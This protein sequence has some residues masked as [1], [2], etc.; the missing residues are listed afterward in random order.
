MLVIKRNGNIEP[1]SLDKITKRIVFLCN[2]NP[3]LNID[4]IIVAVKTVQG[5]YNKVT[6][7]ELDT[8]AAEISAAL[9]TV[10]PDFSI[11]AARIS[12]SNL[13]KQ[14]SDSFS[15]V[16]ENLF[17]FTNINTNKEASL[18]DKNL[19]NVVKT[20][21]DEIN[22]WICYDRDYMFDY[23]GFKTLERSYLLKINNKIVE[24]PQHMILRVA[25]GIHYET[26]NK[27]NWLQEAKKTYDLISQGFFTHATPTLFN[28]GT[29]YPQLS[30]CFLL[31]ITADSLDGIYKTLTDCAKISKHAGG[32]G[33]SMQKIRAQNSYIAGTNGK[34]NGII[35]ML[36][37]Y[38]NTARYVD[39][40]GGKR[41]GSIA[42]FCKDTE[43]VTINRGVQKIQDVKVG[44]LVVTHKNR[45]KPVTQVHT[46]PLNDR[47]I[48]KLIVE[49]SKDVYVTGNHRFW[50]CIQKTKKS[51]I[52][53]NSVETLKNSIFLNTCYIAIPEKRNV[54]RQINLFNFAQKETK[55]KF[56]KQK[57]YMTDDFATLI[58]IWFGEG[59]IK[60]NNAGNIQGIGFFSYNSNKSTFVEKICK[61]VF[62]VSSI[63]HN[64]VNGVATIEI[65]LPV[66]G[67]IFNDLFKQ[68]NNFI[69]PSI[70][71]SWKKTLVES[72]IAGLLTTSNH[73]EQ[74]NTLLYISYYNF[75]TQIYHLCKINGI[76]ASFNKDI[77]IKNLN[78]IYTV[79][80]PLNDKIVN[81]ARQL[82][83]DGTMEN[84]IY[85][86]LSKKLLKILNI[87]EVD[88]KDDFV[89]T[90]GVA[91]DHS[92]SV[93]G[94]LAENCYF[95]PWH[96]D[97][98]D[99]LDLKKNNGSEEQ[100]A[101][102]LFYAMWIP[103]LFM[104]RVVENKNWSL[105]C[106]NECPGL[107]ETHGKEFED[108]YLKYEKE[109]KSRRTVS[110]LSLMTKIAH[111]QIE[112]GNP[113]IL[114]KDIINKTSNQQNLG[115]IKSSNLC[116]EIC[117]YTDPN[118]IAVCNLASICLP[119]YVV[120]EKFNHFML[121]D[122][123]QHIVQN[124]NKV[125]DKT[126][127]P[128]PE[129]KYSNL[130]HRPM[131]IGVQGLAD[132]FVKLK[133]PFDSEGAK[134]LNKEIFETIYFSAL[135]TSNTLAKKFGP[136]D[137]FPNSPL[138]KG[139]FHFDLMEKDSTFVLN[140]RWDWESLRSRIINEG[141]YNSLF[142]ALMPT[143]STS[144]IMGNNDAFE[145]FTSNIY[146][147]R[148][149]AGEFVVVN[150]HLINDLI[151][152]NLWTEEI[153]ESLIQNNG[154]VQ[155]LE[156]PVEI[157]NLYKTAFEIPPKTII[158]MAKD[159]QYFVDQSQSMNIFIENP[160]VDKLIKMH[161]YS[162]KL[163]LKTGLYYLRTK[164]STNAVKFT[165]A[166]DKQKRRVECSEECLTCSA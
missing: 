90:L 43:I 31:D 88:R 92:Y 101:R 33:V 56:K 116:A 24:R 164:P 9:T 55:N 50:S 159:R 49:K 112:T 22:S 161:V 87:V 54:N 60:F 69:L 115:T 110:A 136:Y 153:R 76:S 20:H 160:S 21:S 86:N 158:D 163:G 145:P 95:E 73:S 63:S 16:I 129:A 3:K 10:H 78:S 65:D 12:V 132:V 52:E 47:K 89:Y 141:V 91:D 104:S 18:I 139:K 152:N 40:G 140:E 84:F 166:P 26:D 64:T 39:Q 126:Y 142:V 70:C 41:K 146:T 102:D 51:V 46:N 134:V 7:Q 96:A 105:F 100:R 42:C 99:V 77:M 29:V 14:T 27:T 81:Q 19:Y 68:E 122:I 127:Y 25:L 85:N 144:Q 128:V 135:S 94:L 61:L 13:H 28:S 157:K 30:S 59:Y 53:W 118:E 137:S 148:L 58:G 23:F 48:Y 124:L 1:V 45:I 32:I 79:K 75:A 162:W 131:G 4:P 106:P 8:L 34:S 6:T 119:K 125:I 35:P 2:L 151:Q 149:L 15:E 38:N 156:I 123:V 150:K 120:N 111:A 62:N 93:E 98:E 114:F 108:L 154:S 80:I 155:N 67:Y 37:V 82:C 97:I 11:L 121:Y 103:D 109:G 113:Y 143:A 107:C 71:F 117:Q 44:D 83:N 138:S 133:L 5:L 147:R 36:R 66:V 72:F 17:K 165:I 130:K 57:W 74:F